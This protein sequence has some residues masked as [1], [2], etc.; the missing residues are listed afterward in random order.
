MSKICLNCGKE[1]IGRGTKYCNN[2]CQMEYAHKVYIER[3]KQ[4]LET[5]L[6][7]EYQLSDHIKRYLF[8]T[9]GKRCEIC[10][11]DKVNTS[12]NNIPVEIHHIDGNYKNNMEE[13][14]QILCPN[15]HSLTHTYKNS[16]TNNGRK[17]R[18]KYSL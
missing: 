7:G 4:G 14:L 15:C 10:G 9:R 13:N 1:I 12:T 2:V 16:N 11:W 8:E 18:K 17:E 6:R 5:G 3:W